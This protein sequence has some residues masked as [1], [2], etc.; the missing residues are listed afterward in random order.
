M[1]RLLI[2]A[3]AAGSRLDLFLADH[4][5]PAGSSERGLSRSEIQRLIGEGQ[6]TLNGAITKASARVRS[7]DQVDIRLLP[8]RDSNLGSEALPLEILY[9]DADCIVVNKAPESRFIRLRVI[10]VE[11]WSTPCCIIVRILRESAGCAGRVSC[12]GWTKTLRV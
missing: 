4:F 1:R 10:G 3:G 5:K 2:D 7:N 12:T 6:I 8:P 11:L 9:E